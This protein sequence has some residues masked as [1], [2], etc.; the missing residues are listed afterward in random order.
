MTHDSAGKKNNRSALIAQ[1]ATNPWC[2]HQRDA[3]N[4]KPNCQNTKIQKFQ[5]ATERKDLRYLSLGKLPEL[6]TQNTTE[7][8]RR[9]FGGE[10][11]FVC[12]LVSEK[13]I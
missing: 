2:V 11:N 10:K 5:I 6:K 7:K 4:R 9:L 13:I 1:I 3:L 8:I 12:F